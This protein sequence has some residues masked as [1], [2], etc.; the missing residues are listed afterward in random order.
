[1]EWGIG[2][3]YGFFPFEGYDLNLRGTGAAEGT[4]TPD[5]FLRREARSNL[6]DAP[7]QVDKRRFGSSALTLYPRASTPRFAVDWGTRFAASPLTFSRHERPEG[8]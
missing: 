5:F 4:R 8:A 6:N 3:G 7:D 2:E 1:M